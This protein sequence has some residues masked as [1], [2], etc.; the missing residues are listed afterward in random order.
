MFLAAV[1]ALALV[2][3]LPS[4]GEARPGRGLVVAADVPRPARDAP[5]G[6]QARGER[7]GSRVVEEVVAV[8]RNPPSAPARIVTY[9]KLVEE[10]RIA[11]VSRGATDAASGPLDRAALRAALDWLVDQTLVADEAAKLKLDEVDREALRAELR[12]FQARFPGREAYERFLGRAE[13]TEDELQATLA[14]ML[15][16]ERYVQSRVGQA[17][18]VE[19]DEVDRWLRERG[20]SGAIRSVAR[21]EVAAERATAQVHDLLAEL[22]SRADV[23]VV[24]RLAAKDQG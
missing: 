12:R 13:L 9:T 10:A 3:G 5:K 21:S 23:R 4:P 6:E 2:P 15:R 24:G 20:G 18:R 17:A 22:R 1:A 11:L 7:D 8:I 16:V 14:R 19:D